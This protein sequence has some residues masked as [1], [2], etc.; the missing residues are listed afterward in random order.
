MQLIREILSRFRRYCGDESASITVEAVM[1]LPILLWGYFGLFILYDGYRALGSNIRAGHTI[2]DL[3]SRETNA[4]NAAYIEGLNDIQDI[5]T[6]SSERTVLR[7]TVASYFDSNGNGSVETGEHSLIWSYSTTGQDAIVAANFED[8]IVPY[9]PPMPDGGQ[10]IVV[11]TWM[12][13]VPFLNIT[14]ENLYTEGGSERVVFGPFYFESLVI[15]RPR[16]AGQLVWE[17]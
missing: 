7:V 16:F 1:V 3:L 2:S 4:V 17:S 13:H 14:L 6:Q 10:L 9:L 12:A 15:T 8:D 11:E 5:L